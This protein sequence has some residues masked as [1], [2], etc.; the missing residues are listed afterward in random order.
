[1]KKAWHNS[2]RLFFYPVFFLA[3]LPQVGFSA[4]FHM[5]VFCL[6][7]LV[8]NL[9]GTLYLVLRTYCVLLLNTNHLLLF[10]HLPILHLNNSIGFFGKLLVVGHDQQG[11]PQLLNAKALRLAF[12]TFLSSSMF[13]LHENCHLDCR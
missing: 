4:T 12:Q 9:L 11:L 8:L 10:H 6:S 1:M 5:Q 13:P 2:V 3:C 7:A